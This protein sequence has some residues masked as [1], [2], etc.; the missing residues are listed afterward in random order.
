MKSRTRR[1]RRSRKQLFSGKEQRFRWEKE[2]SGKPRSSR[3]LSQ[4][5]PRAQERERKRESSFQL[6]A[7]QRFRQSPVSGEK[8]C[9][10]RSV[11]DE[12]FHDASSKPFLQ[13]VIKP[14]SVINQTSLSFNFSWKFSSENIHPILR[15]LPSRL[16]I[17]NF[18]LFFFFLSVL[19]ASCFFWFF[20]FFHSSKVETER[21]LLVSVFASSIDGQPRIYSV[22]RDSFPFINRCCARFCNASRYRA[23][24]IITRRNN[25]GRWKARWIWFVGV[26]SIPTGIDERFCVEGEETIVSNIVQF[27]FPFIFFPLFSSL[28]LFLSFLRTHIHIPD[29]KMK[30]ETPLS[31][32]ME[33]GVISRLN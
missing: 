1:R 2:A 30:K 28:S 21:P 14:P 33:I 22:D 25:G 17:S 7:V 19:L 4:L 23:V 10:W 11:V 20:I 8:A 3:K 9:G 26:Q 27:L 15:I 18:F 31:S 24:A 29:H 13:T 6:A 5:T 16:S 32:T 12:T